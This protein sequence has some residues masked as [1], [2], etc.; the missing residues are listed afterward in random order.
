[1]TVKL[2]TGLRNAM[3]GAL[4]FGAT[5]E[6]GVIYIYSGP[7]PL[8]ADAAVTGTLLGIVTKDGAV[9]TFGSP[10]NG[11][12][13]A[14]PSGGTVAKQP[15]D[16]WR[17]TGLTEGTAGWFRLM[18]NT[19]DTLGISTTSA[20]LDG[21][22]GTSGADLNISNIAVVTGSPN[23]VDVFQFTIPAQ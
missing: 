9:F 22:C 1:M 23:T 15:G 16:N 3:V 2:S 5:F 18:A 12:S 17:F 13:F 14:A 20:R 10:T 6:K 19:T 21:S 4:G 7:Q 11:L 8:T